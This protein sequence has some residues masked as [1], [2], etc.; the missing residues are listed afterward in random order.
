MSTTLASPPAR[1]RT[2]SG[3]RRRALSGP[4]LGFTCVVGVLVVLELLSRAG[5]VDRA[6]VPPVSSILAELGRQVVSGPFWAALGHTL[7]GWALGLAIATIVGVAVGLLVGS[8]RIADQALRIVI[9]FLRPVPSVA[10][11]PLA[12]LLYGTGLQSK[13]A[14]VV[15]AATWPILLATS[16]GV[17]DVDGLAVEAGR[18]FGLGPAERLRRIVVPS[19]VPAVATGVRVSSS[20]ALILAVTAELI[21]GSP[22]LGA[23]I[24]TAE[25]GG[26]ITEM[27]AL[28]VATGILGLLLNV[29][30]TQTEGRLLAWHPSHRDQEPVA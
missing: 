5:V 20:I 15:F 3:A 13:V 29:L 26:A 10:L 18:S 12:V 23:A 24:G 17:R 16:Y 7:E 1:G 30:F 2:G 6:D 11:V 19:V 8:S 4:L 25:T 22:G 9:D 14:L 28:V 21:I 27:Y